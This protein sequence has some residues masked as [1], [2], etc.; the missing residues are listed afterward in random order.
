MAEKTRV[1]LLAIF[2][3]VEQR[4]RTLLNSIPT[5]QLIDRDIND[6]EAALEVVV[7][8]KP[9]VILLENDFPG[10]DGFY[11]AKVFRE[12]SPLTQIIVLS[13]VSSA[14]AVRLAMRAGAVDYLSYKTVTLEEL[15]SAIEHAVEVI[16]E[17]K[18]KR[19]TAAAPE[20]EKAAKK[21]RTDKKARAHIVTFYSPKGGTGVSTL[22]ANLAHVLYERNKKVVVIDGSLQYG[23][24]ALLYNQF[25]NRSIYSLVEH[26][27]EL[28][29]EMFASVMVQAGA[30]IIPAPTRPE[31]ESEITGKTFGKILNY[32]AKM[33]Y[34]V[35]LINTSSYINEPTLTALD[36]ADLI[37]MVILQEISSVRAARSFINLM[38]T[39]QLPRQKLEIL[40]N[41][42]ENSPTLSPA[43]IGETLEAQIQLTI[44][45]DHET[46]TRAANLGIPFV[47]DYKDM[48]IAKAMLTVADKL[49]KRLAQIEPGALEESLES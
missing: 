4:I 29:D 48:P 15:S 45:T 26:V 19:K 5:V 46:A 37:M 34:D 41:R 17:E 8:E 49:E 35:V 43:K 33:D 3:R 36:S 13:E 31:Q 21:I 23:D 10:M 42:F 27:N 7:Q 9:D 32:V 39:L 18:S 20:E 28:E 1:L 2:P 12:Q 6:A 40:I 44:P 11:I 47:I 16:R 14:E 24:I 30:H 38:D 22:V 25:T